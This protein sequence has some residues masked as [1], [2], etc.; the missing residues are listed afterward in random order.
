MKS[1]SDHQSN[2]KVRF[3]RENIVVIEEEWFADTNLTD[4]ATSLKALIKCEK[5]RFNQKTNFP[6]DIKQHILKIK[7]IKWL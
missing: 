4:G 3:F 2:N 5:L 6:P 7:I 1:K